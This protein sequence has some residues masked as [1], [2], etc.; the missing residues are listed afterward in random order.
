MAST[1]MEEKIHVK[2]RI[3]KNDAYYILSFDRSGLIFI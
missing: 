2:Q 1:D 3:V